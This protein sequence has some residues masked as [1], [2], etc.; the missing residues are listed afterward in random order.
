MLLERASRTIHGRDRPRGGT[1]LSSSFR[2]NI[3]FGGTILIRFAP[4]FKI[5][6]WSGSGL[7]YHTAVDLDLSA[8]PVNLSLCMYLLVWAVQKQLFLIY[9]LANLNKPNRKEIAS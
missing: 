1:A 3:G 4:G 9:I 6:A 8:L 5:C 2:K 7:A